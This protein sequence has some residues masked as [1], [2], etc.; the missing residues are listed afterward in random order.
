MYKDNFPQK[1]KLILFDLDDTLIS[2]KQWYLDKWEK[3]SLYLQEKYH[4]QGF[5][6]KISNI[7]H[8]H[9]FD[10]T[11]K[12]DDALLDLNVSEKISVKEIV[13]YYLNV[14][15]TPVVFLKVH[16]ILTDLNK[17]YHLG[18]VTSGKKQEQILKI[19]LS[20][21]DKYFSIVE[22]VE[23][24]SK[25]SPTPFLKC[26]EFFNISSKHTLFIGNDPVN[27]FV[28]AKK[29]GIKTIRILQGMKKNIK[30]DRNI[31][32][33]FKFNSLEDFNNHLN[34]YE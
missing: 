2:E 11:K 21:L 8:I 22:V 6:E 5:F 34:S 33:D 9:G 1:I 29:L 13:D 14:K 18:I 31:D 28:G 25:N 20:G 12:V 17:N 26:L 32:S 23:S 3:S 4:V 19:K 16:D 27:D 7:I 15:V 10:Y 24:K 30:V